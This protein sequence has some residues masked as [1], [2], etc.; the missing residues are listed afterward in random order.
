M[1]EGRTLGRFVCGERVANG[2]VGALHRARV[3]GDAGFEKDF[4]LLVVD[5]E[6][7]RDRAALGRLVRAA[8]GWA[9]L[10]YPRIAH[11]HELGAEG[12][13]YF[14]VSDWARAATLGQLLTEGPLPLDA[15]L[16][17]AADAADAVA[18]AHARHDL[19][20]GGILHLGL[21]PETVMVD[22]EGNILVRD[23][24]L[25]TARVSPNWADDD[26][27]VYALRYCA[28]ELL[29]GGVVDQRADVFALATLLFELVAGRPAF[30]GQHARN[31]H[32]QI[33]AS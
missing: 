23:F 33:E 5:E 31:I 29:E 28:P 8:N 9:R 2:P 19:T 11:A 7:A 26:R 13:T 3:F 17:A 14:L 16:L 18:H 10:N 4:S 24:G 12:D 22:G 6:L 21:S 30:G 27:L 20:P 25:L 15:A 1:G 32:S